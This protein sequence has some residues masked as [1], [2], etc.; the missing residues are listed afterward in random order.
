MHEKTKAGLYLS[1][2]GIYWM[3]VSLTMGMAVP[4]LSSLG[5]S[6]TA[7][8]TI[9]SA[10]NVLSV[11]IS[12]TLASISDRTGSRGMAALLSS[13]L[14]SALAALAVL[15]AAPFYKFIFFAAYV[16]LA[17][18]VLAIGPLYTK[19]YFDLVRDGPLPPFG[20]FRAIGS[21]CFALMSFAV[22]AAFRHISIGAVLVANA[23]CALL[24]L[25]LVLSLRPML[26]VSSAPSAGGDRR[27]SGQDYMSLLRKDGSFVLL[28]CG[29]FLVFMVHNNISSFK[30]N[31]L[32][33]LGADV[34]AVAFLN[35]V[36]VLSEIPV[37]FLYSQVRHS[38]SE[39]MLAVSFAFFLVKM[40]LIAAASSVPMLF[41]A[42][43][44]QSFSFGLYS[45]AIVDY[46]SERFPYEQAGKAQGLV[47]N[48]P[49]AA[50]VVGSLLVGSMLD[51]H[52]LGS[53]L[54][55]LCLV[56]AAGVA[57]ASAALRI[58]KKQ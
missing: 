1:A 53:A 27:V 58:R 35:G 46:I 34:S 49:I 2:F 20:L 37:M 41:A 17:A 12:L 18:S 47:G 13:G 10:A 50:S 31:I 22:G 33:S 54:G 14:L 56:T 26:Q 52:P 29:L 16:L 28:L 51:R 25:S 9:L 7:M 39:R 15:L 4:Y 30:A 23:A 57:A 32:E 38:S 48:V 44:L 5:F 11:L 36:A 24:Q 21:L 8:G 43:A 45:P 19:L 3:E 55:A 42:F 6:N 40:I